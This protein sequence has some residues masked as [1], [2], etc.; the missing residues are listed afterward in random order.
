MAIGMNFEFI[1][2]LQYQVK[3]LTSRIQCFE[4]GEK[5][6]SMRAECDRQL[7]AKDREIKRC[8]LE[9][10]DARR[11]IVT[12]RNNWMQVMDDLQAEHAKETQ[13]IINALEKRTLMAEKPN[14]RPI[15]NN[16]EKSGKAPGGQPGHEGHGRRKQTPTKVIEIPTPDEY[17]NSLDYEPTGRTIR[18]QRVG[19]RVLPFHGQ[20]A[21]VS[22]R[23]DERGFANIQRHDLR[24]Q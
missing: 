8:K 19:P 1:S 4:S 2:H 7:A 10:A 20:N 18:R 23:L 24:P 14:R 12:I 13:R 9:I 15:T 16:R 5:Y 17:A 3:A 11:E 6:V 22:I 21:R